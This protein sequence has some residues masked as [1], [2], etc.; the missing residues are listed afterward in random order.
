MLHRHPGGML[1]QL[2]GLGE[3][4][5]LKSQTWNYDIFWVLTEERAGDVKSRTL[6][7]TSQSNEE[8]PAG[9]PRS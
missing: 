5:M 8:D 1:A 3:R 4:A 2:L 9:V 7:S 6:T